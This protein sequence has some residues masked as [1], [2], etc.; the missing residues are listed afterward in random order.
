M[1]RRDD[2]SVS[3]D[4]SEEE[5]SSVG[6]A[7][8]AAREALDL[9][10]DQVAADLRIEARYLT[11]L[12]ENDF[13]EFSA[14]VFAKGYLKQYS[15]RLDLDDK[16]LLTRYYR[17]VGTQ[18][19]PKLRIQTLE[20]GE[21]QR[22]ARWLIAGSALVL[23]VAAVSIWQLS[24]PEIETPTLSVDASP[25]S[26]PT[27]EF[28]EDELEQPLPA[29]EP[30]VAAVSAPLIAEPTDGVTD[31]LI[32]DPVGELTDEPTVEPTDEL[33]LEPLEDSAEPVVSTLQVEIIFHED[34]WTEVI[35]ARGERLFY[36][37]GSAGA[38]SR[39]SATPPLSFFLGNASG[40]DLSVDELPFE[41][42]GENRQGN[43]ARF[44]ILESGD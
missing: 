17:H 25:D 28:V 1:R 43:L 37:L 31:D 16:E 32:D 6:E 7:L 24:T 10:V 3:E 40:V 5:S 18:H 35:D 29:A 14:P 2:K 13:D 36:G 20:T 33:V 30:L 19:V 44:V 27:E 12:E 34:C 41:I 8:T 42:P 23:V 15:L 21:D 39:F 22:Q 11:A 9:T 26:S 4:R 38:R